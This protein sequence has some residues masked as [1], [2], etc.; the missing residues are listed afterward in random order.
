MSG[1]ISFQKPKLLQFLR[2]TLIFT[3]LL[4]V[5]AL[6]QFQTQ[7]IAEGLYFTSFNFR[8]ALWAG[9]VL[10]ILCGILG[11]LS[12]TKRASRLLHSL[13]AVQ[14]ALKKLGP[15]A[16]LAFGIL[17]FVAPFLVLGFY[18]RFLLDPFPRLFLFWLLAIAGATLLTA[19]RKK[20]WLSSLP[21]TALSLAAVYLAATFFNL[22]RTFPF[23]LEW[24]E[25]SRYYQASFYFSQQIYG[26]KLPL[27][28]THPSRY[29]LQSLPF[30]VA[31]SPLWLH[32]LWQAG[33]WVCMP[34]LTSWLLARRLKFH[35]RLLSVLFI[36]WSF[37][38]LMQGAVFYHLL[39]CVFL[40]LIGFD[41]DKPARSFLFV[42][43]AS[44][45]AGISR[46]N[47][48]PL[49][50]ALATLLYLLEA[51]P[52]RRAS[53]LSLRYL[54]QP[55]VYGA[56]GSLMALAS[57][58]FYIT[59]S[60]VQ[61]LS[62]FGSA[63]TSALLWDRLLPNAQFPP[64]VILGILLVSAPLFALLWVRLRQKENVPGLWRGVGIAILLAV[65]FFGGLVVSVKIGGGTNL[66]N[67]DAYMV[68]LW[69]LASVVAFGSYA[70]ESGKP[71]QKLKI[72]APL[73]AALFAVP[74]LFAIFSSAPLN[75]PNQQITDAAL[76]QIQ[77]MADQAIRQGGDVLFISQRH[78]LTFHLIKG[79][80][81]V[82][83]YEK[84]FLTEMT[85]S[86]NADYLY[87]FTKDI[88][89]QRF[90]LIIT[91]PLYTNITDTTEDVL[92]PENNAWVRYVS[93]PVLCAYKVVTTFSD[94]N[95]QLLTPRYGDKCDQ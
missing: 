63:F 79:V 58:A 18:G 48:M 40:V 35:S 41:K 55:F 26:V 11:V 12:W 3:S 47:W 10:V 61:D 31:N 95:I 7:I 22:M 57:Y 54:W 39:P 64:G 2:V 29:L 1:A 59:H 88:D 19:W 75:L 70:P 6:S 23:S 50:G 30:L 49:P 27:P 46:V 17:L 13:T 83:E 67:L 34:L 9:Y 65:F 76:L 45:W 68:L 77:Q 71:S 42:A 8:A 78:L 21:I 15:L 38:F 82:P 44:V 37:L 16:L 33:L 89:Q 73:A 20:D 51:H 94:L 86:N 93:R 62:E 80:P 84:L 90:T 5:L 72:S 24:S 14:G 28:V 85:I 32:R 81:L 43:L 87:H 36:L 53:S 60:G 4:G 66:H 56:G 25:I 52:A 74:I 92:S 91:D 69:V